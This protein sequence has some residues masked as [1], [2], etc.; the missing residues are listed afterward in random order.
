MSR[1]ERFD[2]L[3]EPIIIGPKTMR[4]RFYQTP[5][6]T[7]FGDVFPGGQAYHR[8]I[9]AEGGWAVVNTEATTIAPEF[10]WAGQMTPSRIWDDDDVANWAWM[11][12]KI[13]EHGSLAGIELHAGGAFSTNIDSRIP[14]RHVHGRIE[15]AAYFGSVRAMTKRDIGEVQQLY[16]EA[17]KRSR[18]AGFDIVNIHGAEIGAVP[19]QFLMNVHNSRTDEYG[20]SLS[21]RARFWMET[22][23]IV[24]EEVGDELAVAARFCVDSLHGTDAGIRVAEEGVGFIELANHLVDFWDLQV[25]GENVELWIKDAGPA[26][27]YKENFQAEWVRQVRPHTDKPIVGVGRFTSPDT[28]LEAVTSGQL[29]IIGAARPSISDPF[30]PKKIEEGRFEDIRECI[31]CNACVSRVNLRWTLLCT[32][33][34]T[35]GEEYKRGWHPENYSPASNREASVL[36]VGAGSAG[37]ECALVLGK[38][39]FKN[40]HVVEAEPEIG[41]HLRWVSTIPGMS[42]W[43]RVIDWRQGQIDKLPQVAVITNSQL[44]ASDILDYGADI[45]VIANGSVWD[46]SGLNGFSHAAVTGWESAPVYTPEDILADERSVDHERVVVFDIEGYFM[47]VSIAEV[48]ARRGHR[49]S[50]VTPHMEPGPYMRMTGESV[51]MRPLLE[52]LGV[53]LLMEQMVTE[54]APDGVTIEHGFNHTVR[55]IGAAATV[56]TTQRIPSTALWDSVEQAVASAPEESRPQLF[57]IGDCVSP[58]MLVA[59][60]I[61]DGHRLAREIDSEDPAVPLPYIRERRVARDRHDMGHILEPAPR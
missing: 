32:Q 56:M 44:S 26:R 13:H 40:V 3:F 54:V 43:R 10:D 22:L 6:C 41:G 49:V 8:G 59:D 31:G 50:L 25:G 19:V 30:L 45:V 60:A 1:P 52:E 14:A 20:G 61:F 42:T 53:E 37:L 24:K 51:H 33:N 12:D 27:F 2:I 18:S 57:R 46:R 9:K 35:A 55:A 16:L 4:N 34:A 29:D 17:A 23:E 15:E 38:R 11:T 58:R 39:G 7:G 36:I 48:L 5:Q 47:G 28:M 21:N